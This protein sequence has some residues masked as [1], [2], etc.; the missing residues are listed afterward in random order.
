[1]ELDN[2]RVCLNANMLLKP[3]NDIAV[4]VYMRMVE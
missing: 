4:G 2:S 3:L 1:M